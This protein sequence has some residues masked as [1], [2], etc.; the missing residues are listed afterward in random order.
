MQLLQELHCAQC[1]FYL[2]AACFSSFEQNQLVLW[3]YEFRHFLHCGKNHTLSPLFLSRFYLDR[4]ACQGCGRPDIKRGSIVFKC[5]RSICDY[6]LHV[7]CSRVPKEMNHP[8]HPQH[9]LTLF[10]RLQLQDEHG[11]PKSFV[12]VHVARESRMHLFSTVFNIP[13]LSILI[14]D[15]LF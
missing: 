2:D 7:H 11:C 3:K 4:H 1:D 5:I 6:Y 15:V 10:E 14:L 8:F 9:T 12:A 13:A